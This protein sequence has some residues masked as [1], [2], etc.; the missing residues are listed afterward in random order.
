MEGE[1]VI[2]DGSAN[3]LVV[4]VPLRSILAVYKKGQGVLISHTVMSLGEKLEPLKAG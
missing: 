2:P 4:A 3:M 1:S